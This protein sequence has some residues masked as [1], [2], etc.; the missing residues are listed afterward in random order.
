M[1]IRRLFLAL[2]AGLAISAGCTWFVSRKMTA[3]G[4]AA[5]PA[6]QKVVVS[7]H[8]LEAGQTIKAEDLVVSNWLANAPLTTA[9]DKPEPLVGRTLLYPVDKG[10][11]ITDKFLIVPGSTN[12]LARRIPEGMRAVAL[13]TDEVMGVAGYLL[14]DS[15]VDVLATVHTDKDPQ[16][17]TFTV[18]QNA[19]VIAAGHQIQPDPEG[20]PAVATV[21]TLMLSPGDAERAVLASQQGAMHFILRSNSDDER[22]Q[23]SPVDLDGL[24]TG[25]TA[26]SAKAPTREEKLVA[27]APKP[28]PPKYVIDTFAGDKQTSQTFQVVS[29]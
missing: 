26:V 29:K 18:L 19:L 6:G 20:K 28:L 14:P 9:F 16:P 10:Q 12:G 21:V 5:R 7:T 23:D 4:A 27:V 24:I 25:R 22:P 1:N 11:P 13:R 8:D 3:V 2:L 17:L 15:H